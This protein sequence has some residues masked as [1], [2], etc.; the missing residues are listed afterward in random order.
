[1]AIRTRGVD[2]LGFVGYLIPS[3]TR[4]AA[5]CQQME[6]AAAGRLEVIGNHVGLDSV[7]A[8]WAAQCG[9]A[10]TI[11][12]LISGGASINWENRLRPLLEY[13]SLTELSSREH[14]AKDE[15]RPGKALTSDTAQYC[16]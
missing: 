12:I 8:Q 6:L 11:L 7:E 4:V 3:E 2:L 13:L 1:M 15:K 9:A 14:L 16:S 5:N 10:R